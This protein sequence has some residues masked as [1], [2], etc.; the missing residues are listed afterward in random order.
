[1][2]NILINI[3]LVGAIMELLILINVN[4]VNNLDY[5]IRKDYLFIL[6]TLSMLII[7]DN[8]KPLFL[9]PHKFHQSCT[10]ASSQI[11]KRRSLHDPSIASY[12]RLLQ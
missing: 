6:W 8:E 5:Q 2:A 1:M 3:V 7:N 10:Q 12:C 4:S 11:H 9:G